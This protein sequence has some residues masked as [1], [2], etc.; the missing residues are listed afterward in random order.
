MKKDFE[1]NDK[2]VSG[3]VLHLGSAILL[4]GL[5]RSAKDRKMFLDGWKLKIFGELLNEI[6]KKFGQWSLDEQLDVLRWLLTQYPF[7]QLVDSKRRK[8]G[9]FSQITLALVFKSQKM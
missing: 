6:N 5:S 3:E 8:D 1:G 7:I 4:E 9:R 2:E